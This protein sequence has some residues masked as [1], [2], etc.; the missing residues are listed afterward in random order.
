MSDDELALLGH[1]I[2][3]GCTLPRHAIQYTTREL[4]LAEIVAGLATGVFGDSV[5]CT[6]KPERSLA[7]GLPRER[8]APRSTGRRNPVAAWLDRLERVRAAVVREASARPGVPAAGGRDRP[9]PPPPVG[10]GWMH[11]GERAG[12]P[13]CITRRAAKGLPPMS[14]RSCCALG[15]TARVGARGPA[16]W[17]TAVARPASPARPISVRFSRGVGAV[18]EPSVQ[19]AALMVANAVGIAANP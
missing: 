3:D 8:Q 17:T 1:L 2:G 15:I 10:Y 4:E 13:P 18:G 9:V 5:R 14:S 12:A 16:S 19:H 6:I 11:L 7:P